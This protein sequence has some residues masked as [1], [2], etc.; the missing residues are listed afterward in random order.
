MYCIYLRKSRADIEAEKR[1]EGE[2][3]ARH[4]DILTGM[5]ARNHHPIGCIY[6]E[7]V[8]G[9]T[10]SDRPQARQLINDLAAAR[11]KGVYVME[12]ERLSRGDAIDQG[13]ILNAF[14]SSGALI[15]TP[16]RT[17]N[18][19][20]DQTDE[21]FMEFGLF[22]SRQE[23]KT[24][25]RRMQG[26]R[27]RSTEE[28]KFIGS[29]PAYGY[30]KQLLKGGG[31]TLVIHPEEAAI[32]RQIFDWY[33][34]GIDGKPAGITLIGN[35]LT[36]LHVPVGEHGTN[37]DECRVHRTLTNPVYIGII[38]WGRDKTI[39]EVTPTGVVKRRVLRKQGDLHKGLHEPIVSDEVFNAVQTKL[40]SAAQSRFIPVH[41]GKELRNP[42]AGLLIC[43]ECGH[44]LGHNPGGGRQGPRVLCHT[45]G[46]PTV[47]SYR[48]PVEQAIL[49]TLR[50]W[51]DDDGTT[52]ATQPPSDDQSFLRSAIQSMRT[53]RTKLLGQI[54]R[55]HDLLEQNVYS[56]DQYND[57]YVKLT[58]RLDALTSSI[59]AEE[60]T[61][62][63][64]PTYYTRAELRPALLRLMELYPTST[65]AEKNALL[66]ECVSSIIYRK[67]TPGLVL[68]GQTYSSPNSFEL[69][70]LPKMK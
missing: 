20:L 26:G 10:L 67:D 60:A 2:T 69:D 64:T 55:L 19:S 63:A 23:F 43:A 35:R 70:I 6:E 28:G 49:A 65:P 14:K 52:S 1:G 39:R 11:W 22:M 48:E 33:L 21:T 45:R 9:E 13:I 56:I 58:T 44:T 46:C 3:L 34:H 16:L 68:R 59:A 62:A 5:A 42:L 57:R 47:Q 37:W 12:L 7:I 24:H 50:T 27:V 32:V 29:R 15:I 66:K 4:R 51:L 41:K 38:Q 61:L 40:Q 31:A 30:R 25:Y 17:Y 54:D 53:E 8:S 36:D 18:P